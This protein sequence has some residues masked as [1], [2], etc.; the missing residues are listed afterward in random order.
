VDS[1]LHRWSPADLDRLFDRLVREG[2][3]LW[4]P[5]VMDASIALH[6]IRRVKDLPVG[7]T[8]D[9]AAGE[10]KLRRSDDGVLF[11]SPVG[12]SSLKR[13]LHP[14]EQTL[15][16]IERLR[17]HLRAEAP[18]TVPPVRRAVFG[19]RACDLEAAD[20]LAQVFAG[21][22]PE[23]RRRRDA[24]FLVAVRCLR[25]MPTCFCTLTHTGPEPASLHDLTLTEIPGPNGVQR[26]VEATSEAGAEQLE[27]LRLQRATPDEAAAMAAALEE[28]ERRI[29]KDQDRGIDLAAIGAGLMDR[30]EHPRWEETGD[31]C[32]ACGNCTMVCPTCF[33]TQVV[34]RTDP[35]NSHSRREQQWDSCFTSDFSYVAGGSTRPSVRARYRQWLTHKFANWVDQFDRLGCVG[36]GRCIAWCPAA[37]DVREELAAIGRTV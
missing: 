16:R 32:L 20:T 11:S 28:A 6:P 35:T 10:V 25:T 23:V 26:F 18:E 13:F 31:R 24:L 15:V 27:R 12:S 3:E 17:R 29:R 22:D 19:L 2:Y 8:Q 30:L 7:W 21:T 1:R 33:C 5:R 34:E 14:P 37:I 4:G 9:S 36:C